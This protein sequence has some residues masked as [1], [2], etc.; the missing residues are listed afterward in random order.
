L[1]VDSKKSIAEGNSATGQAV[2]IQTMVANI[3][4]GSVI[5]A[6]LLIDHFPGVRILVCR[7]MPGYGK[8]VVLAQ[9]YLAFLER[10]ETAVWLTLHDQG[11][12]VASLVHTL[13][14]QLSPHIRNGVLMPENF[15]QL[16]II[17]WDEPQSCGPILICIDGI[18]CHAQALRQL[19]AF[20]LSTPAHVH[21]VIA[22]G[23]QRGFSRL[24]AASDVHSLH[25]RDLALS[26]D[27]IEQLKQQHPDTV[28]PLF[29]RELH[30]KTQG[31][32]Y[33]CQLAFHTEAP[34][35]KASLWPEAI[36][37]FAE[38]IMARLP[39]EFC[40]F[41]ER[42]ALIDPITADSFDY[43]F[44]TGDAAAVIQQINRDHLLFT[45]VKGSPGFYRLHPALRDYLELRFLSHDSRAKSYFLKRAAFWHWRK[46]EFKQ[47]IE[48]ALRAGDFRWARGL[49][50][51]IILDLALR[52]GEIETLRT[53]LS[54]F[55]AEE[56]RKHPIVSLG[57]AW[58]LYFSQQAKE[59]DHILD[60]QFA[61]G[62]GRSGIGSDDGWP[63]LVRA[64][65]MATHDRLAQ[66]ADL[67]ADWISRY[68]GRNAVGKATALTCMS[69]IA[70]SQYR[71]DD[72]EP[73]LE[74]AHV[75]NSL[76]RQRYAFGW[77][78]V[79]KILAAYGRGDMRLVRKII[80]RA[81]ADSNVQEN[82]TSFSSKMLEILEIESLYEQGLLDMSDER[83]SV[84]FGF[85][86]SYGITDVI[87]RVTRTITK[88]IHAQGNHS[89]ARVVLQKIRQRAEQRSLPRLTLMLELELCELDLASG[90]E[91]ESRLRSILAHPAFSG[92]DGRPLRAHLAL[93]QAMAAL[94]KGQHALAGKNARSAE[95]AARMIGAGQLQI[96]AL[97]CRAAACAAAGQETA[98]T[99]LL[100]NVQNMMEKTGCYQT[101]S[102][103]RAL[104]NALLEKSNLPHSKLE[105]QLFPANKTTATPIETRLHSREAGL[106]SKKQIYV[107]RHASE[108]LS[109]KQIAE[110]LWVSENTI[111]WHMQNIF[112]T[113]GSSNRVQAIEEAKQAQLI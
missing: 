51:D 20:I 65:G 89:E 28:L 92:L 77:Y 105:F 97:L 50:E 86:V 100:A 66:S 109:N 17:L 99:K 82:R 1:G 7:A 46:R 87:Y 111:K 38:E 2:W 71:F 8:S 70:A 72:M 64:V 83:L 18:E 88:R 23:T 93:V 10:D 101:G 52:Q 98:V 3:A 21:F 108:G 34:E 12:T 62:P 49:S 81:R 33:L 4:K 11:D 80:H 9:N 55:P 48:L 53:W 79:A 57:Y 67:C 112:K 35:L 104:L 96:R 68:G 42:A 32:P 59:A 26:I 54:R 36:C 75:A 44:K 103:T 60:T 45:G 95:R 61:S 24:A 43:T 69:V 15:H 37:F 90:K 74:R 25:T 73:L 94:A 91:P 76:A 22:A 113:L 16:G 14:E 107:L 6:A 78:Y 47:T 102:E 40:R 85:A 58:T 31:W 56:L 19:E 13:W 106:L 41:V 30:G 5:R 39:P 27:E 63:E 84:V 29:A 110:R